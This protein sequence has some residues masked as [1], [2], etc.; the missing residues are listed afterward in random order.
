MRFII[1]LCVIFA[2]TLANGM[3]VGMDRTFCC[4]TVRTKCA[5]ACAG[6]DCSVQC[7][8]NCGIFNT[9]CGLYTCGS[10]VNSCVTTTTASATTTTTAATT[11]TNAV[12]TTTAAVTTTTVV[13]P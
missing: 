13:T 11:T 4:G 12:T 9:Y 10:L 3:E 7:Q 5:S 6:L 1:L 8:G 2:A